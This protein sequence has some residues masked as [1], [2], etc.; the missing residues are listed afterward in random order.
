[1]GVNKVVV[2]NA[3]ILDLSSDTVT[4]EKLLQGATAHNAAGTVIAGTYVPKTMTVDGTMLKIS[5]ATV[6]EHTIFV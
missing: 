2:N 1:M 5:P 6:S 3:V 4:P